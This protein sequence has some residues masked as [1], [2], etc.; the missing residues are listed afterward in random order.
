MT[1]CPECGFP[2]L[3]DE[4]GVIAERDVECRQ[5]KWRGSSKDLILVASNTDDENF[6]KQ[7]LELYTWIASYFGPRLGKKL[8]ELNLLKMP[9]VKDPARF[10]DKDKS[11]VHFN[12]K[13]LQA[14]CRGTFEGIINVLMEEV[15]GADETGGYTH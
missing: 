1:V 11:L 6:H 5:C 7:L 2:I 15:S 14:A 4:V 13:V 10:T 3:A 12:A 8:Y 9:S